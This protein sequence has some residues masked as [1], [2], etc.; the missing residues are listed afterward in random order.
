MQKCAIVLSGLDRAED[1]VQGPP[2]V[3]ARCEWNSWIFGTPGLRAPTI[4]H[5]LF[6]LCSLIA[7]IWFLVQALTR[8]IRCHVFAVPH[9]LL[10]HWLNST[11]S[12]PSFL[13]DF[14][15]TRSY[16]PLLCAYTLCEPSWPRI[17][18]TSSLAGW[19]GLILYIPNYLPLSTI[20]S[21]WSSIKCT[22]YWT[23]ID[24]QIVLETVRTFLAL[25]SKSYSLKPRLQTFA[26]HQSAMWLVTHYIITNIIC[27]SMNTRELHRILYLKRTSPLRPEGWPKDLWVLLE[28]SLGWIVVCLYD[29]CHSVP[30]VE[31]SPPSDTEEDALDFSN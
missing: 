9:F 21:N 31:Q 14:S 3:T 15:S 6:P 2:H 4:P 24:T 29:N 30:L 5:L 22:L 25:H 8:Q 28:A 11:L 17:Y 7:R 12:T 20:Y 1:P 19:C 10:L 16:D 13:L 23:V 26:C 18:D 27:K